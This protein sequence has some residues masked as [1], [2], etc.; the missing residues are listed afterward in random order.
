[1]RKLTIQRTKSFVACLGR[2]KIYIEDRVTGDTT[3]NGVP[4]KKIGDLGNGEE[5]TFE[6]GEEA[7]KIF[8]I[9]DSLSKGYCSELYELP[10]GKE[11]IVLTG[12]NRFNPITGNAFRFDNNESEA[13]K[14]NRKRGTGK[15]V[16][17]FIASIVIGAAVGVLVA[18]MFILL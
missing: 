9:A 4:C 15:G 2:M 11:D 8:V 13:A 17:V 3:I 16:G 6:I 5:R 12:K 18:L 14:E 7:A 1:M 10:E